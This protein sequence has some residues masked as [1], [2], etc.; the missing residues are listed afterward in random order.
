[1]DHDRSPKI[2][3]PFP[4]YMGIGYTHPDHHGRYFCPIP[5]DELTYTLYC[6]LYDAVW[7]R[8]RKI[9]FIS[10]TRRRTDLRCN[11]RPP[12]GPAPIRCCMFW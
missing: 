2:P 12:Q 5:L 9:V 1:M 10:V 7:I 3:R 6:N 11:R 4:G 8:D